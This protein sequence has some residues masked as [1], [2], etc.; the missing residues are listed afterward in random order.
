[1]TEA[2]NLLVVEPDENLMDIFGIH[3]GQLREW[4]V[5]AT[6]DSSQAARDIA[7]AMESK[8]IPRI[9]AAILDCN[10]A[11]DRW[12]NGKIVPIE[13]HI[14]EAN[15]VIH[16]LRKANPFMGFVAV[17]VEATFFSKEL[18]EDGVTFKAALEDNFGRLPG[19]LEDL[20]K[21]LNGARTRASNSLLLSH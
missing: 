12:Q 11:E 9:D 1:M 7:T 18:S 20:A 14:E 8:A 21:E 2:L 16:A 17:G 6:A 19:V 13:Y 3:L 5:V 4:D 10:L 15:K